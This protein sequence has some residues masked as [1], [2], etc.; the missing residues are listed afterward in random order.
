MNEPLKRSAFQARDDST[1]MRGERLPRVAHR[2]FVEVESAAADRDGAEQEPVAGEP[3]V[4]PP[5]VV[6]ERGEAA[7]AGREPDP[8]ADRADVVERVP[9]ALEL[10]QDRPGAGEL[11]RGLEAERLL[12]RVRVGDGVASPSSPR[13]RGRRRGARRRAAAPR[14]LARARDACRRAARRRGG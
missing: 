1:R 12:A 13:R 10:E 5:G 6:D 3:L 9:D 14:P 11:G 2:S 8:G 4:Q 7:R